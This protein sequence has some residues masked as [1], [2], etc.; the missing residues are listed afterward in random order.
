MKKIGIVLLILVT[1][2][3]MVACKK[4]ESGAAA[5]EKVSVK[6]AWVTDDLNISQQSFFDAA[7]AYVDYLN[8]TRDDLNVVLNV[9]AAQASV[10]KQIEVLETVVAMGFDGIIL[11]PVDVNGIKSKGLEVMNQGIPVLNWA[12]MDPV[13]TVNLVFGNEPKKG[14]FNYEWIKKY[15]QDNPDKVLYAGLQYGAPQHT[16]NFAR[17]DPLKVLAE[18]MPDRFQILAS[19]NSDWSS[20]TSMKMV[21]DWMQLYKGKMNYICSAAEEQMLGVIEALRGEGE[22]DNVLLTT[23]DAE[24]T[25][26]DLLKRGLIQVDTGII[27]PMG[28]QANIEYAI[29]MILEGLTGTVDISADCT[30]CVDQSNVLDHEKK[31]QVDY[32]NIHFPSALKAD[33]RV[34]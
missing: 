22:L 34:K 7:A 8:R 12:N 31:I 3:A 2:M 13:F 1:A 24:Q 18:E 9:Y 30:V 10:D 14:Q 6:I 19:Q 17:L 33:Y 29:K 23:F 21:E 26:V 11:N 4:T 27:P 15:L 16:Q 5:T 28:A 25:G 32:D 20:E